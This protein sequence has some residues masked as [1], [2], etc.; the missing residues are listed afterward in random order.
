[1]KI[2]PAYPIP[3]LTTVLHSGQ[4]PGESST[5]SL[6]LSHASS[7]VTTKLLIIH[8]LTNNMYNCNITYQLLY[9]MPIYEG[10][11]IKFQLRLF[12]VNWGLASQGFSVHHHSLWSLHLLYVYPT[13]IWLP[14]MHYLILV[15][16][17]YHQPLLGLIFQLTNVPLYLST[18]FYA[19]FDAT[20]FSCNLQMY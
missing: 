16:I 10:R 19:V 20:Q 4:H 11:H 18:T 1:M 12:S 13:R 15:W 7:C 6:L 14:K 17:K 9:S 3:P 2:N 8:L 5:L